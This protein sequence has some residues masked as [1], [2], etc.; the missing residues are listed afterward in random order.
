MRTANVVATRL[1]VYRWIHQ[2]VCASDVE[3]YLREAKRRNGDGSTGAYLQL[4]HG[5]RHPVT[6]VPSAKVGIVRCL[7]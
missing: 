1:W 5:E 4:A 2:L 3:V 7:A 6:G